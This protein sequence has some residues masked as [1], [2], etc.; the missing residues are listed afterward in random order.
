LT[1]V[2]ATSLLVA[3]SQ[4]LLSCF[5]AIWP[6]LFWCAVKLN[7]PSYV[8]IWKLYEKMILLACTKLRI[9]QIDTIW[10]LFCDIWI[11]DVSFM[12]FNIASNQD[13]SQRNLYICTFGQYKWNVWAIK[14]V[15]VGYKLTG[16]KKIWKISHFM[17]FWFR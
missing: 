11:K 2:V 6:K 3:V 7:S 14:Q 4:N 9:S 1:F 13:F 12:L 5:V 8:I 16:K 15:K 10:H 17:K